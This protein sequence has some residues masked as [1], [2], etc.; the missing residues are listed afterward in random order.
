[1]KLIALIIFIVFWL[2]SSGQEYDTIVIQRFGVDQYT[3]NN[4]NESDTF[5]SKTPMGTEI[6]IGTTKLTWTSNQQVAKG[7]GIFFD[8]VTLTPCNENEPIEE[9]KEDYIEKI[10]ITDSTWICHLKIIGNCCHEFLCDISIEND[11]TLNFIHYG[12]GPTYCSCSCC[13]GLTYHLTIEDYSG[14]DNVK[15]VIINSDKNTLKKINELQHGY[16]L[17]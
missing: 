12:Y 9:F 1:M 15:Y 6:L 2:P 11:N 17:H 3:G 16:K 13:F 5:H 8:H 10:E 4:F 7:Y 14:L